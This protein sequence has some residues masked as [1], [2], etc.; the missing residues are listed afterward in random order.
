MSKENESMSLSKLRIYFPDGVG[1]EG[2]TTNF[3]KI[4]GLKELKINVYTDTDIKLNLE[5]SID[6]INRDMIQELNIES[7]KWYTEKID[8]VMAYV[9][10]NVT[11]ISSKVNTCLKI[12]A[13]SPEEKDIVKVKP[14]K[15]NIFSINKKESSSSSSSSNSKTVKD[16]R[17]PALIFKG[18]LLVGKDGKNISVLPKG[19]EGDI[20]M[21]V[22]GFPLW[23][24]I[25]RLF[26]TVE[27]K[28]P[29]QQLSPEINVESKSPLHTPMD[30]EVICDGVYDRSVDRSVNTFYE[31]SYENESSSSSKK[32]SSRPGS[33][34]GNALSKSGLAIF[35]RNKSLTKKL[36]AFE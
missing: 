10:F 1:S 26:K 7:N 23:V 20:L 17:I 19:N 15:K 8:I 33:G 27:E 28:E 16:E 32:S 6:G 34:L 9:R 5:W 14:Q 12:T 29:V 3:A 22:D 21:M 13:F 31:M 24:P 35:G 25:T 18:G 2:Y 11:H 30:E 36:P 4:S